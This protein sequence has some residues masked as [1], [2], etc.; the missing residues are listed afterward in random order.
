MKLLTTLAL[1]GLAGVVAGQPS[2][3]VRRYY[4]EVMR[5]DLA[6]L[7]NTIRSSHPDPY[8]YHTPAEMDALVDS[9]RDGLLLPLDAEGYIKALMPVLRAMGDAGTELLL[10]EALNDAYVHTEPLFPISVAVVDG[11][12]YLN[13]ELKGFQ[14]LPPGCEL[15]AINGI[16]GT[17]VLKALRAGLVPEGGNTTRQDRRIEQ[18]FPL[19]YRRFV[20]ASDRFLVHFRDGEG[21]EGERTLFAITGDQIQQFHRK[22][23]FELQPW[24]LEEFPGTRSAW[25]TLSTLEPKALADAKVVPDKYLNT[26]LDA[27]R[28]NNCRTLVIDLRGA[29]GSDLAMAEQ[30]F[31][32]VAQ[33]PYRMVSAISINTGEVPEAYAGP[34]PEFYSTVGSLYLPMQDGRR[35]MRPEDP[36][37]MHLL[38]MAKTFSGKVYVISN[39]A[40]TGAGA[41]VVMVAKRSGRARIVGEEAGSNAASFCGGRTLEVALPGSGCHLVFPLTRYVPNGIP[42]GALD[43][44]EMPT[45]PVARMPQDIAKGKDTV[46]DMLLLLMEELK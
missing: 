43:H 29:G 19:L 1:F 44:G 27:L 10:P 2:E 9:V 31:A 11:K 28:K 7:W 16:A 4:P 6:V 14:S 23:A 18:D 46:R 13:D 3:T 41:A 39:G 45:Y 32:M 22:Q 26:A 15:L 20:G 8:R 21:N 12:L 35:M 36:R 33:D 38:P 25:L 30:V 5:A 24:R 34:A 17:K 37:L 42:E 40:T